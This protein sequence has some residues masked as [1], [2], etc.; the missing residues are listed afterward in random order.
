MVNRAVQ[1]TAWIAQHLYSAHLVDPDA[2]SKSLHILP[3]P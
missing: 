1:F 3:L 2:D